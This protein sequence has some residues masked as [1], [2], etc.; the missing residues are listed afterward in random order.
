MFK[1]KIKK[2]IYFLIIILGLNIH[3]GGEYSCEVETD[4]AEPTAVVHTV[5][6]LGK[7]LINLK[8]VFYFIIYAN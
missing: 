5:E 8:K 7:I 4:D 6:I 2:F 3:D 1:I